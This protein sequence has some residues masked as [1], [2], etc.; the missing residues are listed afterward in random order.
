[1]YTYVRKQNYKRQH[2]Y[3]ICIRIISKG[4]NG[5]EKKIPT[6]IQSKILGAV[7]THTHM[8]LYT[9]SQ[10]QRRTIYMQNKI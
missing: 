7:Q 2:F 5:D 1:M 8:M 6:H 9:R 4:K 3:A 10:Q